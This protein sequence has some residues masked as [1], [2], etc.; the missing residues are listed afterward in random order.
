MSFLTP[1]V[2]L[3]R[4]LSLPA[5]VL[6]IVAVLVLGSGAVYGLVRLGHHS[7]D[8]PSFEVKKEEF[9]DVL[10][11]RG[12]IKATKSVTLSAPAETGDL[13]IL[14]IIANGAQVKA[15]DVVVEF[16][17]SKTEQDMAQ[18]RSTLKSAQAEIDETHAQAILKEEEDVTAVMKAQFDVESA[19]LEA[20]KK[21]IVSKID[22]DEANLKLADAEQKLLEMEEQLKSDR[23]TNKGSVESKKLAS[24]KADYDVQTAERTLANMSLRAPTAGM[25]SLVNAWHPNSD[26]AP[27]KPGERVWPGAAIAEIPDASSLRVTARVDETERGRVALRQPVTVQLD[28]IPDRQFT[29]YVE[30]IGTIATSDF[31]AGWPIPRNFNLLIALDQRDP[32]LK[33]GMTANATVVVD[34]VPDA[35]TIPAL[36]M[37]QKSGQSVAYVWTGSAFREQPIEIGRTS[38]DRVLVASGLKAGDRV[39]L[40][41]PTVK[42]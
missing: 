33:P 23:A 1:G 9:L 2:R 11:F 39:A 35:I 29:G 12:E 19:K 36:A 3:L 37:F 16:D 21:E 22:G 42:E 40:K 26:D 7:P 28:A 14:K 24:K 32:R 34:R 10:Q 31:S 15:G 18:Y 20:S 4:K 8:V 17:K 30:Q 41:D 5:K 27:Y 38:R 25:V 6:T 13:E